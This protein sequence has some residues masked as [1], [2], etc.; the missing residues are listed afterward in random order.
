MND[1]DKENFKGK[2]RVCL[3]ETTIYIFTGS[4]VIIPL[5]DYALSLVENK[6]GT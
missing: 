3:K 4:D 2:L 5:F 1:N 6:K